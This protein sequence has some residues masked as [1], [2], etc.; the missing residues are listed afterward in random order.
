[1]INKRRHPA[2]G[3][4]GS[5]LIVAMLFSILIGM[6]LASY[7]KLG[8]STLELAN[9]SFYNNAAINLAETGLEHA[10]WS[11]NQMVEDNPAAWSGWTTSGRNAW[12][13]FSG[14]SYG[15]NTTGVA[16]VYVFNYDGSSAP[17]IVSRATITSP[18]GQ[19]VEKW[20]QVQLRKRSRFANGLVAKD[21][22][23]FNGNNATVDSWN[24]DPDNNSAT[25]G[26]PYSSAVRNDRGTVGSISVSVSAVLVN[27]ADIWGYAATGGAQPDVGKNG[28]I[29]GADSAA[30]GFSSV[31]PRRVSTDFTA[32]FDPVSAPP[33]PV[34]YLPITT[35]ATLGTAGANTT[36]CCTH[37][38]I[39]GGDTLN[40]QGNVTLI[41]TA[42]EPSQAM[43]ITGNAGINIPEGASLRVYAAGGIKIA[44]NGLANANSSP[45]SCQVWGTSTSTVSKQDIH[46]AGNGDLKAICYAPNGSVKINGNGNVMG[47]MVA[48]DI[49]LTGNAAFHYD[50]ALDDMDGE[51]PFGITRWT[52]LTSSAQRDAYAAVLSFAP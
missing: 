27:N 1:M 9:R 44:G 45:A 38:A 13:S 23:I 17:M 12:R 31:D 36:I 51:A 48:N 4:R 33:S 21:S 8:Q 34:N 35:S 3:R 5:L 20:V 40:I 37:V 29:L 22:I 42:V 52:E 39:A 24:S 15:Q 26:I 46:I 41:L 32:D 16:R 47:S 19:S 28:T 7:I 30:A 6:F 25:P 49:T 11:I 10:M 50:E 2:S 18:R 43:D 14:A